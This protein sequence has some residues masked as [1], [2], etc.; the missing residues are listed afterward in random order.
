MS[1]VT[2]H[3]TAVGE[4]FPFR[5]GV[6]V[7]IGRFVTRPAHS[8]HCPDSIDFHNPDHQ[9][10][11]INAQAHG[12]GPIVYRSLSEPTMES[13]IRRKASAPTWVGL[14]IAQ[15]RARCT[16]IGRCWEERLRLF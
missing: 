16:P 11:T 9:H 3:R 15:L 8:V 14:A 5:I 10:A 4:E 6:I 12:H 7:G 1:D 2:S 13:K